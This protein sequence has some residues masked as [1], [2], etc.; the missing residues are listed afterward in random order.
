[1]GSAIKALDFE[2]NRHRKCFCVAPKGRH[3]TGDV[4]QVL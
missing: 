1:V 2:T 4:C 3:S